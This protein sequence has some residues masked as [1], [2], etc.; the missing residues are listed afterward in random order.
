MRLPF[1]NVN[2]FC[3]TADDL[4]DESPSPAEA[5]RRLDD[6]QRQLDDTFCGRPPGNAFMALADTIAKFGLPKEPFDDL[7]SAFRQDQSKSRYQS[8]DELLQ[9]CCL[10]ANPV[11]RIVL[12]LGNSSDQ[13]NA[14]LSDLICTGLQLANFWQDVARDRAIRRVYVPQEEMLRFGVSEE[15]FDQ[16]TT[17]KPLRELLASE[18]KRA[19]T[20]FQDGL[21]LADR[22]PGWLAKNI[23]L[24]AHGGLATLAAIRRIDFDVLRVRPTVSKRVQI[25]LVCR[26]MLGQL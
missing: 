18:C 9:Y 14:R 15:M 24:F 6:F 26:A 17:P 2:A 21:P 8:F 19:E 4:A 13:E 16:T 3:R 7:L 5:L 10:S 23:K 12:K 22:V 1:Y 11:G 25:G 20:F